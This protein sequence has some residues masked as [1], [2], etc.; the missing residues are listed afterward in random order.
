MKIDLTGKCALVTGST[1]GIGYAIAETLATC[2]AKVAIVGRDK[3]KADA[4]A[5]TIANS[6]GFGCDVSVP[7]DVAKLVE[8]VDKEFGTL[9]ILVNNAGITKDNLMLRL[10]DEDWNTVID[11]NLRSA[12]LA[13]RA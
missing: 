12:F 11:S 13:I 7:A 3:A 9:D 2:G 1:R 4:I 8:D 6:R 5:G 10:K